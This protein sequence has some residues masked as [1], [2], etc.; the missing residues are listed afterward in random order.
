MKLFPV[1]VS[2]MVI[3][4]SAALPTK[5][6]ADDDVMS[7]KEL[8]RT[9]TS[10]SDSPTDGKQFCL[11]YIAGLVMTVS[12]IQEKDPS[13]RLFCINPQQVSLEEVHQTVMEGLKED[14]QRLNEDAY[15]LVSETLHRKYPCA[16]G[17]VP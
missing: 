6:P 5:A 15:V 17:P 1:L 4:L 16:A 14:S 2:T 3:A 12:R 13:T 7:G 11:R 10:Q 9:C 8:L